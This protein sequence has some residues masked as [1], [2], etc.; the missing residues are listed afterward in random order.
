MPFSPFTLSLLISLT[1]DFSFHA[2]IIAI[3]IALA[4]DAFT[5]S[6]IAAFF[7]Y[8]HFDFA[9]TLYAFISHVISF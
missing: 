9:D 6:A 4:A 7:D 2:A 3:S 5:L 8:F 1:P